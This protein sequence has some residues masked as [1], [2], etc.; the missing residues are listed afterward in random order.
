[1]TRIAILMY[2]IVDEPLSAEEARYCCTPKRFDA[3]M[4][5]LAESGT[6]LLSLDQI[7]DALDGQ[8][9]MA[10]WR[11]RQSP[12]TMVLPT[13]IPMH[14]PCSLGTAFRPPCSRCPIF[15]AQATSGC[16]TEVFRNG[17]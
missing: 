1:M 17:G 10:P 15:P 12:S 6:R 14:Y 5:H 4:R 11:R 3:Q 7:A 9:R 16:R 2:H 13:H 8:R